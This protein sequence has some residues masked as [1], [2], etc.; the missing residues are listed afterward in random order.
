M[1]L[2]GEEPSRRGNSKGRGPDGEQGWSDFLPQPATA[3]LLL[4]LPL[5]KS[6]EAVIAKPRGHISA[7]VSA[8]LTRAEQPQQPVSIIEWTPPGG[9]EVFL[10]TDL[11]PALWVLTVH[12]ETAGPWMSKDCG[13][14][15]WTSREE[16]RPLTGISC[17]R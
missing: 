13:Q 5:L 1:L 12:G 9:R 14:T 15:G 4:S 3:R 6:S 17:A 2:P 8:H 16:G 10:R 11:V 7:V